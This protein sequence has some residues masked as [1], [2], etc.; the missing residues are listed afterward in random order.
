MGRG[1]SGGAAFSQIGGHPALDLVNTVEWRRDPAR[2]LD[3]LGRYRAVLDWALELEI[4][5][6]AER[7][8]LLRL[9]KAHPED[10]ARE[11]GRV[12]GLREDINAALVEHAQA[13]VDRLA[14]LQREAL[15]HAD[16]RTTGHWWDW[17]E[18]VLALRTPRDRVTRLAVD[19]MTGADVVLVHRCEDIACGW[20]YLDRSPRRN[21]RWCSAAD[22][23]NRN[24]ARR[25]YARQK[26]VP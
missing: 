26:G 12:T 23:G 9:A 4:I 5:T 21:R 13:A 16:L 25:Y 22:C 6:S 10:A 11:L 15:E 19:L 24:R 20:L 17:V 8:T 7:R 18:T 3:N 1:G 14:G 2:A